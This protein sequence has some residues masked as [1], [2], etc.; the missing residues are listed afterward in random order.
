MRHF[1]FRWAKSE[2]DW[3]KER[4]TD[5]NLGWANGYSERRAH[6]SRHPDLHAD[7]NHILLDESWVYEGESARHT[8]TPGGATALKEKGYYR[9]WG[10]LG[11]LGRKWEEVSREVYAAN[12]PPRKN[13]RY[14]WST[15][16]PGRYYQMRCFRIK[17]LEHIWNTGLRND[18]HPAFGEER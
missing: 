10:I 16:S 18:D 7:E 6:F 12:Q 5:Y 4:L 17:E 9:R 2:Y 1:G 15:G 13:E 8:W 14:S 3:I 11:C